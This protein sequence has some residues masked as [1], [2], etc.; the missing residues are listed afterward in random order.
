MPLRI[1][2]ILYVLILFSTKWPWFC[3]HTHTPSTSHPP[4]PT[5]SSNCPS[6]SRLVIGL[7]YWKSGVKSTGD[8]AASLFKWDELKGQ[9]ESGPESCPRKARA[10]CL[11]SQKGRQQEE[12]GPFRAT[13]SGHAEMGRAESVP[14]ERGMRQALPGSWGLV[15]PT[16]Q[17]PR[18]LTT[19]LH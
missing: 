5:S 3:L 17:F 12:V 18:C 6:T 19:C 16:H 7:V 8:Q 1:L 2:C 14:R 4:T 10:T 13:R 15:V 9:M 11:K